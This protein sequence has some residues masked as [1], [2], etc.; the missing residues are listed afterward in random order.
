MGGLAGAAKL[1]NHV[2][3]LFADEHG[4]DSG[5][6]LVGAESVVI[7]DVCRGFTKQIGVTVNGL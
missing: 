3:Q 1:I 2:L 7:S 4:N 6:S 5:R